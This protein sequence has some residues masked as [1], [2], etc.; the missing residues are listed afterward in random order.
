MIFARHVYKDAKIKGVIVKLMMRVK[1]RGPAAKNFL[2]KEDLIL[3]FEL[4]FMRLVEG[5]GASR[6]DDLDLSEN[7]AP[8]DQ[9]TRLSR[10]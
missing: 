4:D 8:I 2:E 7:T 1:V 10:R 9:R 5:R 3:I 6:P